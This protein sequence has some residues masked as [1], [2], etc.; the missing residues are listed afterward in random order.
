MTDNYVDARFVPGLRSACPRERQPTARHYAMTPPTFFAVDYA[1]NPWMDTSTA[2]DVSLATVQW[3]RLRE[4]YVRLGHRVDLI[5]P[6]AGLPDMVYAANGG[7]VADDIAIVARF[8]FAERAE[9]SRAYAKWMSSV[10]YR[11][12]TTRHINE[13]QG[14]L[15]LIGDMVLA[16]YGFRTDPRAHAEIAAALRMPVVSLELVDPRFYHLD[17][18]LAVLDE[19]TI[20]YYPPA[21][22]ESAQTQL[23]ALF[24]D[25]IIVGTSDAYLFGLNA[26]SDGRH[27]VLPSAATGFADQLRAAGFEP[28][29]V[30][31]S[32]LLKGGGSVKCCTLEVHP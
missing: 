11:P 20:A 22:S 18:A 8:R 7:F 6:V 9:E 26:V 27:V 5:E 31:L 2:V 14:D 15:M 3:E 12:V 16:G 30:D 4:T 32:E 28:I 17:T 1:I 13:G 25:A 21:F 23:R 29:G 10:G 24:A 19:H